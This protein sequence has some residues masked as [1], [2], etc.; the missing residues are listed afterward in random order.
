[1]G[2]RLG[3]DRQKAIRG[4]YVFRVVGAVV[5]TLIGAVAAFAAGSGYFTFTMNKSGVRSAGPISGSAYSR[6]SASPDGS[7][8]MKSPTA[9]VAVAGFSEQIATIAPSSGSARS[10]NFASSFFASSYFFCLISP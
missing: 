2:Q 9:L 8:L 5:G 1:M 6:L 7:F 10:P 4:G 3:S